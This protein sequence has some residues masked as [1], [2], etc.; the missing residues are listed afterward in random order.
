MVKDEEKTQ[1]RKRLKILEKHNGHCN[2]ENLDLREIRDREYVFGYFPCV[3]LEV[4]GWK[5]TDN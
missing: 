5:I 2:A 3:L 4:E 1:D